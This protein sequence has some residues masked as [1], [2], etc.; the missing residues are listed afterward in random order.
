[1]PIF[2]V[3]FLIFLIIFIF[4]NRK[5]TKKITQQET[6]IAEVAETEKKHEEKKEPLRET[7]ISQTS[8]DDEQAAKLE[9]FMTALDEKV[10]AIGINP[11]DVFCN[12]MAD[13]TMNFTYHGCQIGR[14]KFG[15]RSSKMQVLTHKDV[16]WISNQP[17][18]V[19]IENLDFWLK[20]L[21][22]L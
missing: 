13:G 18:S 16:K 12:E 15:R 21:K 5:K 10:S 1:M 9:I 14:V 2:V 8:C 7:I 4:K 19:Y 11:D 22:T 17:L 3:L 20:Y 6:L